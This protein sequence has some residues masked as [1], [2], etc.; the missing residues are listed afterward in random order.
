MLYRVLGRTGLR[1]SLAGLGTGGASQLGQRTGR[2]VAESHQVVHKALDL[3]INVFDSS[4]SYD[5]S[6]ELLGGALKGIPR[7]RFV[8]ATK[9]QPHREGALDPDPQALTRQ[10][11]RSLKRLGVDVLDVL[12]YHGVAAAEYREVVDRFQPVALRAR[13]SGKVRFIGITETVAGDPEH[14]M[15]CQALQEDLFDTLMVKYGILNQAA[16]R[17][18]FPL[19]QEHNVGVFVMAPV[20]TSLRNDAEAVACINKFIGQGLLTMERVQEDDPLGLYRVG[21]PIPGLTRAAYHFAA[22]HPAVST[23]LMGTANVEHLEKN[24]Q[25]LLGPGLSPA[26]Y[27]YLQEAYGSLSWNA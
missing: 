8:L 19:A 25:A 14:D 11:E 17:R 6:E 20:R 26:Q 7:D 23:V 2:S 4:P 21:E 5:A 16:A 15:L 27:G 3:G 18:I 12:Q 22:A 24:V 9:F 10:L 13:E 1:V